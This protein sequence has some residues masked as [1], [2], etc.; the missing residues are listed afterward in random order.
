MKKILI[1]L[2]LIISCTTAETV[3][4]EETLTDNTIKIEVT[5]SEIAN[6]EIFITYYEYQTDTYNWKPYPISYDSSGNPEPVIII[7]ENYNYRYIAGE[8]YRNNNI[9]SKITLKISVN[10]E[11]IIDESKTGNGNEYVTIRFNYD[12]KSKKNI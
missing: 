5:S 6:D 12:I 3:I 11:V 10:D 7:L 4:E 9:P 1:L 8:V 2:I